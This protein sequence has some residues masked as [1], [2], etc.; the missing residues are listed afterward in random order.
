MRSSKG[1]FDAVLG[2]VFIMSVCPTATH[3]TLGWAPL[4]PPKTIYENEPRL[5][6]DSTTV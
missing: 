3:N 2:H 1:V 6:L 5:M 4:T